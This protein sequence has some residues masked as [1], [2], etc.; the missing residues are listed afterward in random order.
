LCAINDLIDLGVRTLFAGSKCHDLV[1]LDASGSLISG[2]FDKKI[3]FWDTRNESPKCELQLQAAITSLSINRGE[4][5][6]ERRKYFIRI[7]DY[8]EKQLLL[9]CSRDDTLKLIELRENRVLH[10]F[11]YEEKFDEK[12]K[13]D[14]FFIVLVMMISKSDRKRSKLFFLLIV[15]MHV[16]VE[17]MDHYLFGIL[18]LEKLK[19]F[20]I[21]NIRKYNVLKIYTIINPKSSRLSNPSS[22]K[23]THFFQIR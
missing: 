3:R 9:A 13:F 19:K 20:L 1:A 15:L 17:M 2:H 12:Q 11:R 7:F 14:L 5:E 21:K 4:R 23:Q 18:Q 16:L 10:T 22:F 6:R 8:L